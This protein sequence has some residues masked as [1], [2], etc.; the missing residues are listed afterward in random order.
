MLHHPFDVHPP[1]RAKWKPRLLGLTVALVTVVSSSVAGAHGRDAYLQGRVGPATVPSTTS[2]PLRIEVEPTIDDASMLSGWIL[3]RDLDAVKAVPLVEGHEQW[4]VVEIGGATYDYRVSVVAMR[5]G[6]PVSPVKEPETCEC[7]SETL[8]VMID[9][10]IAAAVEELRAYPPKEDSASE[11][12][13]P[14]SNGP[15][16]DVHPPRLGALGSVGIGVAVLGAGL[17][18]AGIPLA[19]QPDEI[20][21]RPD[22]VI[23]TRS[24]HDPGIG[25]AVAGGA[26]LLVGVSLHVVD[27]MR[28]RQ[29]AVAVVPSL[30]PQHAGLVVAWRLRGRLSR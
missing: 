13:V 30:R 6:M 1:T 24:T 5:D 27:L 11:T 28:R 20:R 19:L 14:A 22:G 9:D 16:I 4:I 23:E 12:T 15:R 29:R 3:E 18:G 21:T 7:N 10:R 8:L 2:G 26:V 25:I 17:L